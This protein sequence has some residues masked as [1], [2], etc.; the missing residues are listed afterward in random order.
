[1]KLNDLLKRQIAEVIQDLALNYKDKDVGTS[2]AFSSTDIYISSDGTAD[3]IDTS[4]VYILSIKHYC[5]TTGTMWIFVLNELDS[6][7]SVDEYRIQSDNIW[8]ICD[9]LF[10]ELERIDIYGRSL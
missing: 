1:M 4:L 9:S 8:H 3:K 6:D 7:D 10:K 5:Y 2:Y